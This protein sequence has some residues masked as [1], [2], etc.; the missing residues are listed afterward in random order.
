MMDDPHP[1]CLVLIAS[2]D[3]YFLNQTVSF[4]KSKNYAV[5]CESN[6]VRIISRACQQPPDVLILDVNLPNQDGFD[7][8][9]ELRPLYAGPI[10]MVSRRQADK[11]RSLAA[12]YM[13]DAHA[14]MPIDPFVLEM[15]VRAC[16]DRS[17]VDAQLKKTLSTLRYGSF[18]I[19]QA[20]RSVKI[21]GTPVPLGDSDFDLL[22]LMAQQAGHVLTRDQIMVA[23]RGYEHDGVDR[24]IDMRISRLR[25]ILGECAAQ[26]VQIRTVRNK[27]YIFSTVDTF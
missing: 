2:S 14:R 15:Q 12:P 22:W 7:I 3:L 6:G 1:Q 26:S 23:L 25:K 8:C 4:F 5:E 21:S 20:N 18:S 24:S 10:F 16:L 19:N 11:E 13:A 27:G 17:K 9:R